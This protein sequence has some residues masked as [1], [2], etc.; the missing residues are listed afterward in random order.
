MFRIRSQSCTLAGLVVQALIL[1]LCGRAMASPEA[2]IRAY[3]AAQENAVLLSAPAPLSRR[4]GGSGL[5]NFARIPTYT[6]FK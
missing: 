3:E 4:A 6:F 1:V 2:A 5:I